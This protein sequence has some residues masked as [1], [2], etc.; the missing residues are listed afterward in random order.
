[1]KDLQEKTKKKK[2]LEDPSKADNDRLPAE[3]S[4][5]RDLPAG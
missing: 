2:L 5:Q 4:P 3:S 1:M